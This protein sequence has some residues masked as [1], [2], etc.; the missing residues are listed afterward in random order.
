MN[1]RKDHKCPKG[2]LK[3]VMMYARA[4]RCMEDLAELPDP[5]TKTEYHV[6]EF[7]S[8]MEAMLV[9]QLVTSLPND[10]L[11]ETVLRSAGLER[12][13]PRVRYMARN[14]GI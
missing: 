12:M 4:V 2:V 13:I 10:V 14:P 6:V 8:E 9:E 1:T 7:L 3:A 11:R 5:D